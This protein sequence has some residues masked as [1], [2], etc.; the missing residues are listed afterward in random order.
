MV[1]LRGNTCI[2]VETETVQTATANLSTSDFAAI[3][4]LFLDAQAEAYR[5]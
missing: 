2:G 1:L 4:D 3:G 5:G